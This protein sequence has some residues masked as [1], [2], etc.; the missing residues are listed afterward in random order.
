MWTQRSLQPIDDSAAQLIPNTVERTSEGNGR[1]RRHPRFA[2]RRSCRRRSHCVPYLPSLYLA[3]ILPIPRHYNRLRLYFRP[4][5]IRNALRP[6]CKVRSRKPS[7]TLGPFATGPMISTCPGR[8]KISS[9]G[10]SKLHVT[11]TSQPV[12]ISLLSIHRVPPPCESGV[13][14]YLISLHFHSRLARH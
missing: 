7:E 10:S 1:S 13:P 4:P 11:V 9:I 6:G 8:G 12:G 2:A 14:I 3:V 5:T